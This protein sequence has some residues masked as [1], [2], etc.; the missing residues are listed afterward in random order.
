MK[1]FCVALLAFMCS[2]VYLVSSLR[3]SVSLRSE[4]RLNFT[5]TPGLRPLN[6]PPAEEREREGKAHEL[7]PPSFDIILAESLV[8]HYSSNLT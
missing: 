4:S 2:G 1:S 8:V 6:K 3:Q 5:G 7:I